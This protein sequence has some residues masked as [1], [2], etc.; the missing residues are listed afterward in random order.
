MSMNQWLFIFATILGATGLAINIFNLTKQSF[1]GR[2][3]LMRAV[4]ALA[5]GGGFIYFL[6]RL[7]YG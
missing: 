4:A 2:G 5:S 1:T 7:I 6:S 3:R